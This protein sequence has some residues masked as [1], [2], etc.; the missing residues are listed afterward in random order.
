MDTGLGR[1]LAVEGNDRGRDWHWEGT[2][3]QRDW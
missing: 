2:S 3:N 1:S